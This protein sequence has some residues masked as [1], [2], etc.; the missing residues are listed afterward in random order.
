MNDPLLNLHRHKL[1]TTNP[2]K[3]KKNEQLLSN[4]SEI[5]ERRRILSCRARPAANTQVNVNS[6]AFV[7]RTRG[8]AASC[9]PVQVFAS[10]FRRDANAS[11][12]CVQYS[13][14]VIVETT[15]AILKFAAVETIKR[16][17]KIAFCCGSSVIK[18]PKFFQPNQIFVLHSGCLRAKTFR[19][20]TLSV[21]TSER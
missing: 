17:R 21:S 12:A 16:L 19:K 3:V 8:T 5:K 18:N 10:T 11:T 4:K 9:V 13:V 7:L 6:L 15:G 20:M 14:F 2:F 1:Q